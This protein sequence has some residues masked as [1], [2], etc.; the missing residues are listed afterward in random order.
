[1]RS[2]MRA[3]VMVVLAVV[4]ALPGVGC[5][6][7]S[8]ELVPGDADTPDIVEPLPDPGGVF[9][10]H[11][12]L[13]RPEEP[14][15]SPDSFAGAEAC[16]TCHTEHA[17][18]WQSSMHAY[19]VKDPVFQALVEVR[20]VDRDGEEDQF[21]MQCHTA[22]GTRGGEVVDHFAFNDLSPIVQ[23][24]V[25]CEAC[26]KVASMERTFN[27]GHVLDPDGP[28]RGSIEDPV[29]SMFHESEYSPLFESADLCGGCHD[30]IELHG[31]DLERPYAEW[32]ESPA[33]EEG[34]V[35]Q[36]CHMPEY[37]GVAAPGAP[38]RTLHDHHF[39]GVDMPLGAGALT[40]QQRAEQRGRIQDL[41]DTA[42]TLK[43][44]APAAAMVGDQ[45]DLLV[46]VTNEID[47]HNLPTGTTFIRQ[48]WVEVV[49]T[50]MDG[51]VLYETGTL[52]GN[53][54]LRDYW[55]DED[56]YGDDDL[57]SMASGLIGLNGAPELFPWRATE[58]FSRSISPLY[59]RT[60]T[61]FIPTTGAAA[62]PVAVEA[63][64][65]FRT[66]PPYL[67]RALGLADLLERVE[68]YDVASDSLLVELTAP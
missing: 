6:G 60:H 54:D 4:A 47:A 39:V 37:T 27:S 33:F 65:R 2:M 1:M 25:T 62:G 7:G 34:K 9:G 16:A 21:C 18:Q 41:L 52:D 10:P 68:T 61:L 20:Q 5:D 64:L 17:A 3:G 36:D 59:D 15:L 48:L 32:L 55:S 45:I 13:A 19:A 58:H 28:M 42:A 30:V 66:H 14:T 40:E 26:H 44:T 53:G 11:D 24:G 35:C 29:E 23:E 57:L 8:G 43:L 49:V 63:R 67:L 12:P 31:L 38:E 51:E 50:D 46:T 22:I 56:P